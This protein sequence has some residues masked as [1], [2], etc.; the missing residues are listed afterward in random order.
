M[1]NFPESSSDRYV[2]Y[3]RV[4]YPLAPQHERKTRKDY[5]TKRGRHSTY[6]S[7]S[8]AFD[9]ISSSQH[10]DDDNDEDNEGTSRV[11]T[12]SPTCYVNSLSNDVPQVFTNLPRDYQNIATLFTRQTKILNRQ[13]QMRDEHMSKDCMTRSS[14]KDL[15]TPFKEL[16]R[17]FHSTRKLFKTTSLDYSSSPEFDLFSDLEDHIEE[18]VVE[19]MGGSNN[20]NAN[21][22]IEKVLKIVKFF[23]IPEV[24][25]DQIMLRVFPMSLSGV[26]SR[27]LR[28]EPA[29]SIDTW[30][31]LKKKFLRKYCPQVILFYKGLDV[32]TRQILDSKGAIPSMKAADAKKAIQDM[33]DHSQKWHNETSTR[34]RS[35]DTSDGLAA[36]QA[37]LNNLGREIK[38]VNERVYAA[39][40]S[41]K[42]YGGP[43]YTKDYLLKEEGKTLKKHSTLN[44][45]Y[46]S[47]KKEDIEQ[48]LQDSTKEIMEILRIKSEDNN[49]RVAENQGASIK[50]LKILIGQMSKVLQER[51]SGS[52]P[53]LTKTNSRDHVK[54]ISTT[55]KV[56]MPSKDV[57]GELMD[58]E[59]ISTN[60]KKLLIEKPRMRYQI[61]ASTNTHDSAILD[62]DLGAS[63]SVMRYSTFTNLGLGELA[64]TKLI[65]VLADRTIKH[66]K[67]IAEN[68]LVV[69]RERMKLDLEARLMGEALILNILLDP[70]YRDYIELNDLNKPL[71]IRRNQVEDLGPTIEEG[72][73]INEPI[74]DIVKTRNDSNETIMEYIDAYRDEGLGVVIVGKSFCREIC[75]KARRFDGM[76]TIY[77]GNDNVTYQMARSHPS[78]NVSTKGVLNLG[79]EYIRDAKIEER[80]IR[81]HVSINEME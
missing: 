18:E 65:I 69:L 40:V 26:A 58:R 28:N 20:E 77:N 38:K 76:I 81:G 2:L 44:L 70:V 73:V 53:S 45:E 23:H 66:P 1:S 80:L 19:P 25:Q 22:H 4:M 43:H 50:A 5:C 15:F 71:E 17:V 48:L 67:G 74:E 59:K 33:A 55:V 57:L 3:D 31:T 54:S 49:G 64:P 29:R 14:T 72:E 11:S 56:D 35:T 21:E 47:P 30:E 78:L 8:S 79:P 51:G 62:V 63:V 6:A 41:C 42:S 24:T 37:Q 32:P 36:I 46:H 13:V 12:R 16:E 34:T 39:Q 9:H 68:V 61:E 75:I 27:W 10:I 52:L 7:S 60:L